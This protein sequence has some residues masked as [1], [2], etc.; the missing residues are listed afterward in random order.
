MKNQYDID[1]AFVPCLLDY[2]AHVDEFAP[3]SY[4][5]GNWGF[6][7]PAAN[8]NLLPRMADAH[9]RGKLWMQPVSLQDQRPYDGIYDEANNSENLRLTWNSSIT[10]GADWVQMMTW[11]DY[12]EHTEFSPSTHTGWSPLDISSYYI[13]K[14]KTGSAPA[15]QRDVLYVS[16]RRQPHA[17]QPT[18]GQSELM[19][20][21]AGSSPA[22]DT[23]EVLSFLQA[24]SVVTVN[25][26]SQTHTYTAPAGVSARTYPLQT[27][28]VSARAS[29]SSVEVAQVT[30]PFTVQSALPVQDLQYHFAGSA[31]D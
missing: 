29:R 16:H 20:L 25:V 24:E 14:Y 30:S 15:I 27:G 22:R 26:G 23:V 9:S 31:R 6:R 1:I 12:S 2:A 10:G 5:I 4:G 8:S 19:S 7:S 21:R 28:T 17:A 3:I 18:G 11:N 13:T